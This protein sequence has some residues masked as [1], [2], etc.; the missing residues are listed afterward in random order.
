M[1]NPRRQ[2]ER[3]FVEHEQARPGHQRA[4]DCQHLQLAR[5]KRAGELV[6]ALVQARGTKR[7]PLRGR[8]S[9]TVSGSN[10]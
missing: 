8:F 4:G 2:A 9:S 6:S 5:A 3:W 1:T 10:T 7:T